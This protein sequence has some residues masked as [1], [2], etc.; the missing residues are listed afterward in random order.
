M[1]NLARD[2]R[3]VEREERSGQSGN[4]ERKIAVGVGGV[5]TRENFRVC[6]RR[7][8]QS[9]EKVSRRLELF[10]SGNEEIEEE[11]EEEDE[12]D[13]NN[14]VSSGHRQFEQRQEMCASERNRRIFLEMSSKDNTI[15]QEMSA[16][17]KFAA[18]KLRGISVNELDG[19]HAKRI[20]NEMFGVCMATCEAILWFAD[21]DETRWEDEKHA[22]NN[23][24]TTISTRHAK[25]LF[26]ST[27]MN[28]LVEIM[29]AA[30][31]A[32]AKFSGVQVAAAFSNT[33][34]AKGFS[35]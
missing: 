10:G 25:L 26:E 28:A 15:L 5:D 3:A 12:C 11:E 2:T 8:D 18:N 34:S 4:A 35:K 29:K 32:R 23:T 16:I 6:I 21:P 20:V 19:N 17:G 33:I 13:A 24:Y 7:V 30:R 31:I 9:K 1:R 27:A 22:P 14:V